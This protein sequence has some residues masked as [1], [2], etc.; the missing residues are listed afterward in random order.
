MWGG[1]TKNV[2]NDLALQPFVFFPHYK[3]SDYSNDIINWR[4]QVNPYGSKGFFFFKIFFN[5]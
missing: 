1:T 2:D 4:K 5:F 3:I